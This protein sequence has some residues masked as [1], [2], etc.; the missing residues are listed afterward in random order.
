M[1]LGQKMILNTESLIVN[2]SPT[3]SLNLFVLEM[4]QKYG[5]RF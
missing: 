1:K 4:E 2:A 5:H 3:T